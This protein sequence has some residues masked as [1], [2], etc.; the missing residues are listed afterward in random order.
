MNYD[1]MTAGPEM[2]RL[3]AEKVM[4][5]ELCEHNGLLWKEEPESWG[6]QTPW[7]PSTNIA[8][9]WEV[10]ESLVRRQLVVRVSIDFIATQCRIARS[11][12][13]DEVANVVDPSAP[14]AISRAALKASE[15]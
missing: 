9:A 6:D 13:G 2:D 1:D 8:H 7:T 15:P 10:V 4:G 3:V 11:D 12:F 14:L 5:W